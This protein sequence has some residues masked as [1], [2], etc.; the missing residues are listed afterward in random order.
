[1]SDLNHEIHLCY[2]Y[3][4]PQHSGA[5]VRRHRGMKKY[6]AKRILNQL[7]VFEPLSLCVKITES[8][9]TEAQGHGGTENGRE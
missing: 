8:F 9:N 4:E 5:G 7:C 2:N 6:R 3:G 1:M